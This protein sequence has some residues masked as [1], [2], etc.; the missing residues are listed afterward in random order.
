M[1][2]MK[3]SSPAFLVG[4]LL[5]WPSGAGYAQTLPTSGQA[6][7]SEKLSDAERIARLQRTIE[8]GARRIADL[9]A[10]VDEPKGEYAQAEAAF[11]EM[12]ATY[13]A[14][15]RD[16]QRHDEAGRAADS[17]TQRADLDAV[18]KKWQLAKERFDLAIQ[19]RKTRHEQ[20]ATLEQ[21]LVQDRS[22]LQKLTAIPATQPALPVAPITATTSKPTAVE[23]SEPGEAD[24]KVSL[25]SPISMIE[26][27]LQPG[28]SPDGGAA[29]PIPI[30]EP[31]PPSKELIR[32][33]EDAKLKEAAAR[34]AL[35]EARSI[36]ERIDFLNRAID[37]ER[38][39]LD[40]AARQA[41]NA[42]ETARALRDELQ[43]TWSAGAS[44]EQVRDYWRRIDEAEQ[45]A[46]EARAERDAR[47]RAVDE[48]RS[49]LSELQSE[50]IAALRDAEQK[51]REAGVAQ[52]KVEQL[53]NP[54]APQN[55]WRWI[56]ES[57]PKVAGILVGMAG[58]LWLARVLRSRLVMVL[59]HTA[60]R[61]TPEE[62]ENRAKTLVA[63]F[64]SAASVAIIVGGSM[65][66]LTE[67]GLNIVP[68]LG[69]AAV[70]GLAVAFG[71]QNL[72]RDYFYGFMILLENQY[73]IND[74]VSIGGV[75]G[76]VERITLR[77]TVLRDLEGAVHFI[78]NGQINSVSNKTHLWSR[79][80][81]E[82]GVAY[83]EDI[84]RVMQVLMHLGRDLRC[85]PA[86]ADLILEDP[87]MLGVN[88]L[89]DSSVII[90]LVIKTRPGR[91]WPVKREMLRR[92]KKR[93]DELKIEIP[94]PHRTV[95]QRQE[96][97]ALPE[98]AA[99]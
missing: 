91:Q 69:G 55:I 24:G 28:K 5:A 79:A 25:P 81:L 41:E 33:S 49:E 48:R 8:D 44:Q 22:A 42:Q 7:E 58:L 61:G 65:M 67:L 76:Q 43:K 45:R 53:R 95:Y 77:I 85:D 56:V 27:A 13:A 31:K 52:R 37:L 21:K 99:D 47:T 26:K 72:I 23:P 93:F 3:I 82:I 6:V 78:P 40:T 39:Q 66:I 62:R 87:E 14:K 35:G 74:V 51:A 1:S 19:D 96:G 90:K 4:V 46:R 30:L 75:S 94:Y 97:A 16:A 63:V 32:A 11:R 86:F 60:D 12:D 80:V 68:L 50:Q 73:G 71:A 64:S 59:V 57:G 17:T 83:K 10:D 88:Q 84:D 29:G 89:G 38:K 20:A 9:R 15:K 36:A 98:E 70:I 54:F 2:L 92:I 18:E 34:Q